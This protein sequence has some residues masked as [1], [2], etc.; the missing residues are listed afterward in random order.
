MKPICSE[1][2][3]CF[4]HIDFL[5]FS[6]KKFGLFLIHNVEKMDKTASNVKESKHQLHVKLIIGHIRDFFEWLPLC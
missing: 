3:L 4:L 2:A 1:L 6:L 5:I